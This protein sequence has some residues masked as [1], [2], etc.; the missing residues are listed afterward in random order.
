MDAD[1]LADVILPVL[2][3]NN[4]P[5]VALIWWINNSNTDIEPL[6]VKS[7]TVNKVP[8]EPVSILNPLPAKPLSNVV[9]VIL[10]LAF[11]FPTTSN[12]SLGLVVPIPTCPSPAIV[13]TSSLSLNL[14]VNISLPAVPPLC[15]K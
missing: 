13:R 7:S 12:F 9:D 6:T 11:M 2:D 3:T 4:E 10:S 1:I 14:K 8:D 15:F 5:F